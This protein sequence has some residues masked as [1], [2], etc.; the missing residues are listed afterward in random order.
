[1]KIIVTFRS[2]E[3]KLLLLL[4]VVVMVFVV[5]VDDDDNYEILFFVDNC[6]YLC[7]LLLTLITC[8]VV[9]YRLYMAET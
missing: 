2:S 1:M 7:S 3:R 9:K 6:F 5:V 8:F 4:F